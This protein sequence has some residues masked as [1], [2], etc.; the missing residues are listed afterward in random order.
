MKELSTVL[1]DLDGT[2]LP[3]DQD[4]FVKQYFGR[5]AVTLAPDYPAERLLPAMMAGVEAMVRNDGTATNEEIFWRVF[6]TVYGEDVTGDLSRFDVFYH[7]EFEDVRQVCGFDPRAGETVK[8][9]KA[10]GFRV[11]L[12]TNPVFPAV[13]TEARIRWAGLERSALAHVTTYENSRFCKP[14]PAY[15]REVAEALSCDPETCLMVGN[16][17]DDDMSAERVG[18]RVFLLTDHLLN[19]QG[20]DISAYPQ[21]SYEALIAYLEGVTGRRIP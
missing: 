8:R 15:Y 12:A 1:F 21:G 13:A 7:K 4:V 16:D 18:M 5:L 17:V 14:N 9:L 6:S 11:A 20:K 19:R 2:L 10:A 3:L